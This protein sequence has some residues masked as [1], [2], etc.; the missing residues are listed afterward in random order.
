M[1]QRTILPPRGRDFILKAFN[2]LH[3]QQIPQ[4]HLLHLPYKKE[5]FGN[6]YEE[7]FVEKEHSFPWY[8]VKLTSQSLCFFF[9][10]PRENEKK[11]KEKQLHQA[12]PNATYDTGFIFPPLGFL[13]ASFIYNVIEFVLL[14]W[15]P[16]FLWRF[17]AFFWGWHPLL[18]QA[19]SFMARRAIISKILY[20]FG[21]ETREFIK[22][23]R[24]RKMNLPSVIKKVF[25][26]DFK[27]AF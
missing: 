13:A 15:M 16:A 11:G 14:L 2:N 4:I 3:N 19:S 8:P 20:F 5:S 27:E 23:I 6:C 25:P 10:L 21:G 7:S 12:S 9:F 1:P 17:L 22:G 24:A 18:L 26:T